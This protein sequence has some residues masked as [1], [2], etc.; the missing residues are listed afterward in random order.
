MPKVSLDPLLFPKRDT[1]LHSARTFLTL[2]SA[3]LPAPIIL[4]KAVSFLTHFLRFLYFDLIVTD[5]IHH[6]LLCLPSIVSCPYFYSAY[7][8]L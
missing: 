8:A 5:R 4:H 1:L 2:S 3:G 6:S 7:S